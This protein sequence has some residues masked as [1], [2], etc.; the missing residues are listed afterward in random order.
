[1]RIEVA[2]KV[3]ARVLTKSTKVVV[4]ITPSAPSD[5]H[6]PPPS[7]HDTLPTAAKQERKG[8]SRSAA[9]RPHPLFYPKP[10]LTKL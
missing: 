4:P 9:V 5:F 1:M 8:P 3:K 6:P 7:D 2:G 10:V